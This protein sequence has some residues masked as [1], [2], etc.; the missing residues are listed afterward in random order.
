MTRPGATILEKSAN[1]GGAEPDV[2]AATSTR[3]ILAPGEA[4]RRFTLERRTPAGAVAERVERYWITRWDLRGRP[5]HVQ[6]TLPHPCVNLVVHDGIV[7]VYGIAAVRD[8]RRLQGRGAAVGAKFRPGAFAALSAIPMID[9]NARPHRLAEVLGPD[10]E[11]LE[12]QLLA[13]GTDDPALPIAAIEAFLAP[14]MPERDR[15]Y[16]LVRA[17][18]ADMLRRAS[19]TRVSA[20]ARDH[21]VSQRTLQRLFREL[22]G[23]GPKWVLRRYRVH[24]AAERLADADPPSLAR[25]AHDLGYADQAHLNREFREAVGVTPAAY[26]RGAPPPA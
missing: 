7:G 26:L 10:G 23:V 22:I 18:A 15:A 8:V 19:S 9:L 14:R 16:E 11:V 5:D 12:R 3:G 20:L 25:L 13:A 1:A 6:Q 17:V 24:E 4:A 21:G 2:D